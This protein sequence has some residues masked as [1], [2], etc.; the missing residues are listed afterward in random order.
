MRSKMTR[1]RHRR[2]TF[3]G[4]A[5]KESGE[6]GRA[7]HHYRTAFAS[8]KRDPDFYVQLGHILKI[9]GRP[10]EAWAAYEEALA[11]EPAF[12]PAQQEIGV[13][14]SEGPVGGASAHYGWDFARPG[15]SRSGVVTLKGWL[16]GSAPVASLRL[17]ADARSLCEMAHGLERPDI[18]SRFPDVPHAA[19][20]GIEAHLDSCLARRQPLSP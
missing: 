19:R 15:E 10:A 7:E 18:T 9:T 5:F 16:V 14:L 1:R 4:H 6:F 8:G 20:A 17:V 11:I 13:L 12:A 3:A 2:S